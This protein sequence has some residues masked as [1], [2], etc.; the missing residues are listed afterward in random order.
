MLAEHKT[1]RISVRVGLRA[2]GKRNLYFYLRPKIM[3]IPL[4]A[5]CV[6]CLEVYTLARP[7][8]LVKL[9]GLH[10]PASVTTESPLFRTGGVLN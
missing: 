8:I 7:K 10:R 5:G 6:G 2:P 4:M 1:K 3:S 9:K